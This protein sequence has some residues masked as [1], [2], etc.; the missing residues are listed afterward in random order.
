MTV[1]DSDIFRHWSRLSELFCAITT[2]TFIL[3]HAA[4]LL[5]G[6]TAVKLSRIIALNI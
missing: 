6:I 5:L 2:L 3:G 4:R 1:L